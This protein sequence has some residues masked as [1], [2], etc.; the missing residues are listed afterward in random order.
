M[1][2]IW[3]IRQNCNDI[4]N[5]KVPFFLFFIPCGTDALVLE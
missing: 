1:T 4:Y 5:G 3:L 2:G